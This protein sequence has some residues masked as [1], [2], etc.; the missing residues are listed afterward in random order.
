M[1]EIETNPPQID[2]CSSGEVHICGQDVLYG[3]TRENLKW[4][5]S[6]RSNSIMQCHAV[7]GLIKQSSV[8]AIGDYYQLVKNQPPI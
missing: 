1:V 4:A 5:S 6:W 2:H 3:V 7:S 8:H